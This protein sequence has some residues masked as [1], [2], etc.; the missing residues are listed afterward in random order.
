[1]WEALNKSMQQCQTYHSLR[2]DRNGAKQGASI[3]EVEPGPGCCFEYCRIAIQ[4]TGQGTSVP[5]R[6]SPM[7]ALHWPAL[8]LA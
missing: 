5:C 3:I 7:H 1:M 4:S 8:T 2:P 6:M